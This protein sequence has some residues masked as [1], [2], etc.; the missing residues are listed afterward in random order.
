MSPGEVSSLVV[1]TVYGFHIIK[2]EDSKRK[3]LQASG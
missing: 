2:V 1:E 3:R